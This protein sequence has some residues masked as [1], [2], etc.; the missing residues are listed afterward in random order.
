M[1]HSRADVQAR[2]HAF[3]K[4]ALVNA[5]GI[6]QQSLV[7]AGKKEQRGKASEIGEDWRDSRVARVEIAEAVRSP[8]LEQGAGAPDVVAGVGV[9]GS[10]GN[11]QVRPRGE[12]DRSG[13]KRQPLVAKRDHHG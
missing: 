11:G 3:R 9:D 12:Q 8:T 10:P 1:L 4:R 13:R 2:R 7:L 5:S 6:V